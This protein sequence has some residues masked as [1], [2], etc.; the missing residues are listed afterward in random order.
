MHNNFKGDL[1]GAVCIKGWYGSG[2][3]EMLRIYLPSS[4][5]QLVSTAEPS[6]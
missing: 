3:I 1:P 2:D 4:S 5:T 6:T